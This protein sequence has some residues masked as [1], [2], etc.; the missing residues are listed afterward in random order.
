MHFE[1]C[2]IPILISPVLAPHF[3]GNH[4]MYFVPH[5]MSTAAHAINDMRN[6]SE[7]CSRGPCT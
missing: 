1:T 6:V 7:W 3:R 4:G 5:A 2:D